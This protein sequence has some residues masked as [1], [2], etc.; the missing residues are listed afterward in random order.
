[1]KTLYLNDLIE[2]DEY[3]KEYTTLK[4]SIEAV[5]E[6]P[7][8]N[9]DALRNGLAEY[10]TYSREEKRNSGRALSGELTQMTT[11]R[12]CNATLGI[13]ALGVPKGKFCPKESPALRRGC[14][15]FSSFRITLLYTR[16]FTIFKL[17]ISSSMISHALSGETSATARKNR[18]RR[19]CL[20]FQTHRS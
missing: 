15:Y 20:P 8:T 7:K 17:S 11:A 9:L 13:F 16:S 12:F 19:S 3:K 5:E 18:C 6:K 2:L 4:K 1:M 14:S 10:D